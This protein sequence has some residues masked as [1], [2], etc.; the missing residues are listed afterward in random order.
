MNV[1]PTA[2]YR[3]TDAVRSSG[4][5]PPVTSTLPSGSSTAAAPALTSIRSPVGAH[6]PVGT[7]TVAALRNSDDAPA[8][9]NNATH[10]ARRRFIFI[11]LPEDTQLPTP[12]DAFNF[13]DENCESYD[14]EH[15]T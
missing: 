7:I 2:L 1:P 12:R 8:T 4:P 14:F 9:S 5:D 11:N 6:V 3:S 13:G 10:D 15:L